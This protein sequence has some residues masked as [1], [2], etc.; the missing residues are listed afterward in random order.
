MNILCG[1]PPQKYLPNF[2]SLLHYKNE[3]YTAHIMN[4]VVNCYNTR[5]SGSARDRVL[6]FETNT[7]D[8]N[9]KAYEFLFQYSAVTTHSKITVFWDVAPPPPHTHTQKINYGFGESCSRQILHFQLWRRGTSHQFP[10]KCF[11]I[12][13]TLH[14]ITY[15]KT[16]FLIFTA[17]ITSNLTT[18]NYLCG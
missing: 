16:V 1:I 3:M 7:D 9:K 18:N 10:L 14:G 5:L 12:L 8:Y 17:Y 2:I 15:Q 6:L 13:I 11:Y 4:T